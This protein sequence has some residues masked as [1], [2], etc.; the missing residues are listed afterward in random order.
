MADHA[1]NLETVLE[2]RKTLAAELTE[3]ESVLAQKKEIF[4]KY[5][6]IVEYLSSLKKAEESSTEPESI[7]PEIE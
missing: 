5:S 1:K 6:G 2:A 7:D 3:L 4:L